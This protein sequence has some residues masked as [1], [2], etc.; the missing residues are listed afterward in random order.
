MRIGEKRILLNLPE[1]MK[2]KLS[3]EAKKKR[4]KTATFIRFVLSEWLNEKGNK[5]N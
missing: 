3:H 2:K 1:E 5:E 4:M